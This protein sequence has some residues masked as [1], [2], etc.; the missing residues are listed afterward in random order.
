MIIGMSLFATSN[1]WI[2]DYRWIGD[3][4]L[5]S[6]SQ[7]YKIASYIFLPF[8]NSNENSKKVFF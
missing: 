2:N 4:L 7:I 6:N 8:I 1:Q 3:K 5:N